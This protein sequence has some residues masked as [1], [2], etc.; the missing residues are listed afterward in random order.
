MLHATHETKPLSG[1]DLN[2]S[3]SSINNSE[4]TTTIQ[5]VEYYFIHEGWTIPP[6]IQN[7][8]FCN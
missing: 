8:T 5:S 6:D 7:C 1:T 3:L 4:P 2:Q